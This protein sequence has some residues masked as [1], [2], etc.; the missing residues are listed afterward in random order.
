[1]VRMETG[2]ASKHENCLHPGGVLHHVQSVYYCDD[3]VSAYFAGRCQ[4]I[5]HPGGFDRY[6]RIWV[7]LLAYICKSDTGAGLPD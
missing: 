7:V 3:M 1:M 2:G 5:R 6:H 4:L